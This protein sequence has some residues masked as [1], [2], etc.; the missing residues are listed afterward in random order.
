MLD[1]FSLF[2]LELDGTT[3]QKKRK[4]A[5]LMARGNLNFKNN[6]HALQITPRHKNLHFYRNRN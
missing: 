5:Q 1:F 3:M 6:A 4:K 2:H